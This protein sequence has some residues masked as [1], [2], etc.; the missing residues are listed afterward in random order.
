MKIKLLKKELE[1]A[2]S[3]KE[4][5]QNVSE[6]RLS[7]ISHFQV[8]LEEKEKKVSQL[9]DKTSNLRSK[10]ENFEREL[11]IKNQK[12]Q[13]LEAEKQENQK[14]F[15]NEKSRNEMLEKEL[16]KMNK[17]I[18]KLSKKDY[19]NL[20]QDSEEFNESLKT[21]LLH[22][23]AK[24][25]LAKHAL[26]MGPLPSPKKKNSIFSSIDDQLKN[27]P[28]DPKKKERLEEMNSQSSK[29]MLS[30]QDSIDAQTK[31]LQTTHSALKK[32]IKALNT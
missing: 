23:K 12:I 15:Q 27:A 8:Q 32:K 16:E 1:E 31:Y 3:I 18:E 11:Q 4:E 30:F 21:N 2:N 5:Y 7:K 9:E 14:K 29:I 13:D 25:I 17:T 28:F 24:L 20:K 10:N 6:E 19:Q 22:T 26:M